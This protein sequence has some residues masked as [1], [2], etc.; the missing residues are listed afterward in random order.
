MFW[1]SFLCNTCQFM[2]HGQER[3]G[4]FSPLR[5]YWWR[6]LSLCAAWWCA[7]SGFLFPA[8]AE[9]WLPLAPGLEPA[10]QRM[11]QV[12][13]LV[14]W[15]LIM[16]SRLERLLHHMKPNPLDHH[17]NFPSLPGRVWACC[18]TRV[19]E[20]LFRTLSIWETL[21]YENILTSSAAA[22][23]IRQSSPHSQY[24]FMQNHVNMFPGILFVHTGSHCR[25]HLCK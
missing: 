6:R 17:I 24:P 7:R 3:T 10:I 8:W 2:D 25:I 19:Y 18:T 22:P 12:H 9:A 23:A 4:G 1:W 15:Q 21:Y 14:W 13:N 11:R 16:M 20:I 5:G